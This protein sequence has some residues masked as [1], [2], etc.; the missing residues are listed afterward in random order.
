M[1]RL[2]NVDQR[3][4]IIQCCCCECVSC[5]DSRGRLHLPAVGLAHPILSPLEALRGIDA[6]QGIVK[7]FCSHDSLHLV[8]RHSAFGSSAVQSNM[9]LRVSSKRL[10][11]AL[12]PSKAYFRPQC[13]Q[14]Q[15]ASAATAIAGS[16]L[17]EGTKNAIKVQHFLP[18]VE[19]Y[20]TNSCVRSVKHLYQT[21]THPQIHPL[22]V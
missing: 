10:C 15:Y 16:N 6:S 1:Q 18:C 9:T 12:G 4:E 14:R 2:V 21:P 22:L 11:V 8:T 3:I 13:L 20:S 7:V 5:Y 19:E 17:P